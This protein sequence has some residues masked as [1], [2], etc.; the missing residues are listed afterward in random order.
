MKYDW[1]TEEEFLKRQKAAKKQ[2]I[3]VFRD[4]AHR[5][6]ILDIIDEYMDLVDSLIE[7]KQ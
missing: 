3:C 6:F 7:V 5:E 4:D 1:E 2:G